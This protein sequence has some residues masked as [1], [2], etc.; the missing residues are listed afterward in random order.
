MHFLKNNIL[1]VLL[2]LHG[3][4]SLNYKMIVDKDHSVEVITSPDRFLPYCEKVVKDDSTV[5]YG[6][7]IMFLDEAK[8]VSAA[9][10]MLTSKKMC[11]KWK[12]G[13][14]NIL[15]TGELITLSGLGN[16]E[17][18]RVITGE[19]SYTFGKHGTFSSNE[20]SMDFFSIRN[21]TDH[22]FSVNPDRCKK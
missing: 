9:A 13:V 22:C 21:D 19:Y 3:C 11:L 18:P 15:D 20:R 1:F 5:A 4:S 17:E 8:T 14:Q 16:M 2:I 10:G 6:F 7:M 12:S